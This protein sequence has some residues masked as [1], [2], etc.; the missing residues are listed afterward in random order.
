MRNPDRISKVLEQLKNL[1]EKY[2]DYRLGQLIS[3]VVR[4]PS[5]YYIE[6]ETLITVLNEYYSK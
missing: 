6:D 2:P 1:W 5:L 4:D 3:N